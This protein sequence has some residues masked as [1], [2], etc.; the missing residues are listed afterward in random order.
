MVDDSNEDLMSSVNVHPVR[1]RTSDGW[2]EMALT[3]PQGPAGPAGGIPGEIKLWSGKTLPDQA[4]YGKWVW[5]DG[6][7]YSSATY[8][9]ASANIATEW[10]TA[11]GA[12]DPGAGNFRVPDLRGVVPMPLDQM[13]GG[14]R[15]NRTVRAV[16]IVVAG[17]A[18]EETHVLTVGELA[19]HGH[20]V[21]SHS[22]GGLTVSENATITHNQHPNTL[23]NDVAGQ[24][25]FT[26]TNQTGTAGI[27]Q[28]TTGAQNQNHQHAINAE[29]PG[30]NNAGSGTAHE[31]LPPTIFVPYIVRLD[32]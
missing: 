8:P 2:Q 27:L 11:H 10:K 26:T 16:A 4:K 5:A 31:N 21:N 1:V 32:G 28:R 3:G 13:P 24:Y 15:A 19:T 20:V 18:G 29:A 14:T 22:H 25:A 7:I 9:E 17:R 6:A 30:T 12:S 23:Y